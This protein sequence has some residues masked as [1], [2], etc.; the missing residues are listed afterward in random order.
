MF[1]YLFLTVIGVRNYSFFDFSAGGSESTF[2][3]LNFEVI[4]FRDS[5]NLFLQRILSLLLRWSDFKHLKH[6][7]FLIN[8]FRIWS[9]YLTKPALLN[10]LLYKSLLNLFRKLFGREI[11]SK[12]ELFFLFFTFSFRVFFF[13][14]KLSVCIKFR[15]NY[16]YREIN[17]LYKLILDPLVSL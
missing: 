14:L 11:F 13:E 1:Q 5:V 3:M 9:G 7:S 15:S 16:R 4:C 6:L 8:F 2:K 10:F 12:L 17:S